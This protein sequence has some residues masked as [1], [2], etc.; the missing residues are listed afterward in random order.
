[1]EQEKII[2][3]K[4]GAKIQVSDSIECFDEQVCPKCGQ[5]VYTNTSIPSVCDTQMINIKDM[6]K[7][8]QEGVDVS[9]SGEWDTKYHRRPKKKK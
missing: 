3:C 5:T 2:T 6:A 9:V 7:M 4:C 1:M 8:A